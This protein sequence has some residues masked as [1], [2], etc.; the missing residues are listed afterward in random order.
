MAIPVVEMDQQPLHP[1]KGEMDQQLLRP[2][3]EEMGKGGSLRMTQGKVEVDL[4]R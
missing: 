2:S 3:K 1:S 4:D